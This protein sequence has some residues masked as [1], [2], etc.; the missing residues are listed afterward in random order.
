MQT[1]IRRLKGKLA[2]AGE[3]QDSMARVLGLTAGTVS[4][5][6]QDG[7]KDLTVSQIHAL[8]DWLGLRADDI[9]SIFFNP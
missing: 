6:M 9:V 4:R 2:E 5:K 7:G 1:D 3:T 8:S